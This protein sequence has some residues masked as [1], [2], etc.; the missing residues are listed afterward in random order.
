V[1][2]DR[3]TGQ[4]SPFLYYTM[5]AAV[6][7]VII[8]RFTGEARCVRADLLM[9]IGKSINPG[10]DRG[11]VVGGFVQGMGWVTTE[12]LCYND[13]GELLS[14]TPTTYKIPNITDVPPDFRV[15]FIDNPTNTMNIR[16]SKAVGEPPLLLGISVW[17]AIK[18]A[19]SHL[20]GR[21]CVPLRIPAT[22]EEILRC[23][24]LSQR[25]LPMEAGE[26]FNGQPVAEQDGQPVAAPGD[27][28]QPLSQR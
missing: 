3:A 2:F 16:G 27:V 26:S 20:Y 1:D 28:D 25:P 24:E 9:D 17:V 7:E 6:S 19:L 21:R 5:G 12:E 10:V 11:Q 13:A 8:D 14:S 22:G 15:A 4:G 23:I 18:D